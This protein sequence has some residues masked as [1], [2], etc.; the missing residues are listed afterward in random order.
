MRR[1]KKQQQQQQLIIQD[2]DSSSTDDDLLPQPQNPFLIL[3]SDDLSDSNNSDNSN[4]TNSDDDKSN[5]I[6]YNDDNSNKI[7]SDDDNSDIINNK[8]D[9]RPENNCTSTKKKELENDMDEIDAALL[10]LGYD[11]STEKITCHAPSKDLLAIN[12]KNLDAK[13]ELRRMFGSKYVFSS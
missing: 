2:S 11:Y 3:Q 12:T 10:E 8:H 13:A 7:D 9:T 5:K 1:F 6:N 4:K